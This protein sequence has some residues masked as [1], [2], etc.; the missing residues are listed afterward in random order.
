MSKRLFQVQLQINLHFQFHLE[1]ILVPHLWLF[2][3][4]VVPSL[5]F[6]QWLPI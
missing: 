1:S 6:L 3:V 4:E 5:S 2:L